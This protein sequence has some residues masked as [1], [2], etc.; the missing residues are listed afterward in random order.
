ML[1]AV[2]ESYGMDT[3]RE[4]VKRVSRHIT[5]NVEEELRRL[6]LEIEKER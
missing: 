5:S 3:A 1:Q 6:I 4:G 2:G